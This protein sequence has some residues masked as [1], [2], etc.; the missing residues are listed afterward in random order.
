MYF[1]PIVKTR[2]DDFFN[3]ER[4]LESLK[5]ELLDPNT[6]M[7][8]VKGIRRIGKSSLMR[9]ALNEIE[10]PHLF[11][12]LRSAGPLTPEAIYDYFSAEIS[13][14]LADKGFRR[15]LSRIRGVEISGLKL[16][17]SERRI[18][19]IGRALQELSRASGRQV[20]LA[21]D[22]AQELRNVRGFDEMLAYVY[23]HVRGLKLLLAGSEVGLLDRFLGVG[24]PRAPLFGRAFSEITLGRLPEEKSLEFLRTGFD[25]LGL[26]VPEDEISQ[27]VSKLDGIIGWLTFYGHLRSRGDPDALG[28]AV[29]EGAKMIASE[30]QHFLSNRQLARRRYIEVLR[31]LTR[32]STWSEVKRG[33]RLIANVSDKQV[34]NYLRELVHYGFVEKR[35]DLYSIADPLLV[36]AVRRGYVH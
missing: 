9:V 30:F 16:E 17:F 23:D 20:I 10:L 31:T 33:L 12:D 13:R 11:I 6:R 24:N 7:I 5:K 26:R 3:M 29:D 21:L 34:S 32:P 35:G 14:F 4:E 36:E 15:I 22:E 1:S 27:A 19:V 28:R 25:Q 8:V 18:G 2:R